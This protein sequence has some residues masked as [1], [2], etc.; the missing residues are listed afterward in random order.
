M[1]AASGHPLICHRRASSW[2]TCG[3][4]P[5]LRCSV[6]SVLQCACCAGQDPATRPPTVGEWLDKQWPPWPRPSRTSAGRSP[7][8]AGTPQKTAP[9]PKPESGR[10]PS[11]RKPSPCCVPTA[12]AR[13]PSGA[14]RGRLDRVRLRVHEP[15]RLAPASRESHRHVRADPLWLRPAAD[16][17]Q[18][19]AAHLRSG[20]GAVPDRVGW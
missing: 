14:R 10:S 17:P 2:R 13:T 20:S 4:G 1:K 18:A 9:S 11:T 5:Q 16:P 19:T 12:V 6:V 7:G 8:S 3:F 15:G